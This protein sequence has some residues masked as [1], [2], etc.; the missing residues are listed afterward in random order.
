[1]SDNSFRYKSQSSLFLIEV[2]IAVF[3]FAITAVVCIRIFVKSHTV[4]DQSHELAQGYIEAD[5]MA[6]V[7][8]NSGGNIDQITSKY[9]EYAVI[10]SQEGHY[11]GTLLIC[12]D[13]DFNPIAHPT[14]NIDET[15]ASCA[16]ELILTLELENSSDLYLDYSSEKRIG[17]A[18]NATIYIF[19]IELADILI[20]DTYFSNPQQFKDNN[21]LTL[22]LDI[23][24]G[25]IDIEA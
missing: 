3:F 17:Y 18:C 9:P 8:I 13:K 23:Y 4:S 19:D 7:F 14:E 24:L 15:I 16:Y 12:Y 25:D 11:T 5:N 20:T 22:P 2:I 1:M 21:I 6:Q 10:L